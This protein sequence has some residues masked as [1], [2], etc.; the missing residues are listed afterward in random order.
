MY[1][2]DYTNRFKKDLQ[3]CKKRGLDISLVSTAISILQKEGKLPASYKPHKLS[4]NH[5]GQWECHIK[6]DWLLVWEQNDTELRLLFLYTGTH[7]DVLQK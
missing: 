1:S 3:R 4:G 2:L 5:E 6:P 7:A